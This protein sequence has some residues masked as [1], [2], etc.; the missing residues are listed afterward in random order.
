MPSDLYSVNDQNPPGKKPPTSSGSFV[1]ERLL[2]S[3]EAAKIMITSKARDIH[4]ED[5]C[6]EAF[7]GYI[8][9]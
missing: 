5:E 9:L 1:P 2:D 7:P 6:N 8:S 4:Y 3:D